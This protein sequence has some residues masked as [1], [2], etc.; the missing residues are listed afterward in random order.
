V[1]ELGLVEQLRASIVPL[2]SHPN[3]KVRSKAISAV[4]DVRGLATEVILEKVVSDADPRVRANAIEAIETSGANVAADYAMILAARARSTHSRERANAIKAMHRLRVSAASAALMQMLQDQRPEH[5]ISGLWALRQIGWW[6]LLN[7]V[8][9]IA[10]QDNNLRVRRYALGIL[11]G[12]AE[13][14]Q[15]GKGKM[16]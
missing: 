4:G 14:M 2:C 12:V 16:G 11:K 5:R 10:K 1:Q 9:Q 13:Q 6:Q 15:V 7:Q 3:A 8:G